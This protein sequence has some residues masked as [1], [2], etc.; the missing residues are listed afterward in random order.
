MYIRQYIWDGTLYIIYMGRDPF[1]TLHIW[2]GTLFVPYK[3]G[4]GPFLYPT[5][6]LLIKRQAPIHYCPT[7]QSKLKDK[8]HTQCQW[9]GI[10]CCIHGSMK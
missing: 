3:Y 5:S 1:C 2:D 6:I 10:F 8:L 9:F 7:K 4:T